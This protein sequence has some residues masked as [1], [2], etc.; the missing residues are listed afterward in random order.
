MTFRKLKSVKFA[1]ETYLKNIKNRQQEI[2]YFFRNY[3]EKINRLLSGECLEI[4]VT[5]KSYAKCFVEASPLGVSCTKNDEHFR[6][7]IP[8]GYAFY[9]CI[10]ITSREVISVKT[11]ILDDHHTMAKVHWRSSFVKLD[12]AL[13]QMEFNII[14]FLSEGKKGLQIFGCITGDEQKA[15]KENELI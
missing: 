4:G 3:S 8:Q 10:G 7:A 11:D 2:D 15:L 5:A 13:G 12:G 6:K 9:K 14:Y 1:M